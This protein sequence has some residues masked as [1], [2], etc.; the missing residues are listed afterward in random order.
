MQPKPGRRKT[1]SDEPECIA[2]S[3]DE[4]DGEDNEGTEDGSG[5]KNPAG[6]TNGDNAGSEDSKDES[7]TNE[8]GENAS[9]TAKKPGEGE[10]CN[11][12]LCTCYVFYVYIIEKKMDFFLQINFKIAMYLYIFRVLS[13]NAVRN[14]EIQN[15]RDFLTIFSIIL[16]R[17][18]QTGLLS[19]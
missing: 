8:S 17:S 10:L 11:L 4:D 13:G 19:D 15:K 12:Y 16:M 6:S 7:S 3:S 1:N 2:L 9:T 18:N 14:D 5:D